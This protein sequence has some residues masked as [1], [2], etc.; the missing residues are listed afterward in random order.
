MIIAGTNST[1]LSSDVLSVQ[2]N[3]Q[4]VLYDSFYGNPYYP[5]GLM[6][7]EIDN[8]SFKTLKI[9]TEGPALITRRTDYISDHMDVVDI[10]YV[11]QVMKPKIHSPASEKV[12]PIT[13]TVSV[14]NEN[15]ENKSSES[16]NA[17][18]DP[19]VII[20]D[21]ARSNGCT[22]AEIEMLQKIAF[23]ESSYDP[24]ARSRDG[25]CIGLFQLDSD[26]GTEAQ[27][28]D[29]YWNTKRAIDYMDDRYGSIAKAYAFRKVNNW[30]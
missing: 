15:L 18:V 13:A 20:T 1:S 3:D 19:K 12:K 9:R 10:H 4:S 29:P 11:R 30:Y 22:E 8:I 7:S 17:V 28:L 27:R 6:N 25:G 2:E 16:I 21:V 5:D 24:E 23:R 26:K 14:D